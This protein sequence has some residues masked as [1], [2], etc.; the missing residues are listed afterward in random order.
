MPLIVHGVYGGSGHATLRL[1]ADP[2]AQSSRIAPVSRATVGLSECLNCGT[3]LTGS[4]C[5]TC[6]QKATPLNP[7]F[8]DL[9]H[10]LAHELLNLDGKILRLTRLLLARPGFVTR[11]YFEGRKASYVSPIRLYLIFSVAFFGL[12]AVVDREP[13][14]DA[15]E[16]VEVGALGRMFGLEEMSVGSA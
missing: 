1:A 9:V 4:Y 2:V 13:T 5:S 11:E 16:Q 7:T 15:D 6:G 3:P 12:S 14:F 10:D 8:R